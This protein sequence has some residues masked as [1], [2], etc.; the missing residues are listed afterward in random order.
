[1]LPSHP[2]E[3]RSADNFSIICKISSL[4]TRKDRYGELKKY[5]LTLRSRHNDLWHL[6]IHNF[7]VTH[8]KHQFQILKATEKNITLHFMDRL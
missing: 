4:R 1:M 2:A 7:N 8:L 6:E 3:Y 5:D